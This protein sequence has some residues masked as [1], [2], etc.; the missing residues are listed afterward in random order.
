MVRRPGPL[1]DDEFRRRLAGLGSGW[2]LDRTRLIRTLRFATYQEGIR[3]VN[4]VARAAEE[5]D[6]HPDLTV[7]YREVIV[8]L[9]SHD[10]GGVTDRDFE[11]ADRIDLLAP[12][13]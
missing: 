7:T 6:H 9:W 2:R 13:S 4:E 3:F 5:M 8:T 10:A 1:P 12:P 11:L